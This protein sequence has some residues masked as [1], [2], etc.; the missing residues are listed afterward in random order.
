MFRKVFIA[1]PLMLSLLVGCENGR[2]PS[3]P[4]Q[5]PAPPEAPAQLGGQAEP[6]VCTTQITLIPMNGMLMPVPLLNCQ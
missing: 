1:V 5:A 3:A 6:E 2:E 4:S